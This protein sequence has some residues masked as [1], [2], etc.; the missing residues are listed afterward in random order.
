M[1][2]YSLTDCTGTSAGYRSGWRQERGPLVGGSGT[3]TG[4]TAR[5]RTVRLFLLPGL[6]L[7]S[8]RKLTSLELSSSASS[9]YSRPG[10]SLRILAVREGENSVRLR[11]GERVRASPVPVKLYV[12]G[13]AST[14]DSEVHRR[15]ISW[16][17]MYVAYASSK[18][19]SAASHRNDAR[20]TSCVPDSWALRGGQKVLAF[21]SPGISG[22]ALPKY[23][24]DSPGS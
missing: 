12:S 20:R 18:A 21:F 4:P 2:F 24:E 7:S 16:T 22:A 9:G 19:A 11:P 17:P 14:R 3:T 10:W 1:R 23:P 13:W 5:H 6:L 15:T 8:S